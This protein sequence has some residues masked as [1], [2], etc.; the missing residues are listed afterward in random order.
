MQTWILMQYRK[1][2]EVFWGEFCHMYWGDWQEFHSFDEFF[3]KLERMLEELDIPKATLCMRRNWGEPG[4]RAEAAA[5]QTEK[6]VI[7]QSQAHIFAGR[8]PGERFHICICYRDHASWQGEVRWDNQKKRRR[9][10]S[11]L[12]LLMLL[13]ETGEEGYGK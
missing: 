10:R 3:Y 12:E 5:R 4:R 13:R 11:A 8:E 7:D 1:C 9:F 2:G 6:P